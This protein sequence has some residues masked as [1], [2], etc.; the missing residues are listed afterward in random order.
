MVAAEAMSYGTPA[1]VPNY[2]GVASVVEVNGVTGGLR[3]DIWDSGSL[4][5]QLQRLLEDSQLWK[6]LSD[7][8]PQV[9]K[10][11]SIP[12]LADRILDH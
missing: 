10:Y 3:F 8:G 9:A 5:D 2:G 7:N 4:A 12:N 11:F 1:V 6:Q